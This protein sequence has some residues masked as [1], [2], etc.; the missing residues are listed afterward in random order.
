MLL[1]YLFGPAA[2]ITVVFAKNCL[3]FFI[4]S[5][6]GIGELANFIVGAAFVGTASYLYKK[7]NKTLFFQL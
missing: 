7:R 5:N 2:A 4:S 3:H 6:F 1:G